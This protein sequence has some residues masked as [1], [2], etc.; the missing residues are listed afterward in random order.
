MHCENFFPRFNEY[1][2]CNINLE[3]LIEVCIDKIVRRPGK[4]RK[5]PLNAGGM[6]PSTVAFHSTEWSTEDFYTDD[7]DRDNQSYLSITP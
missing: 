4:G 6:K 3:I 2:P 5:E 7:V 1:L